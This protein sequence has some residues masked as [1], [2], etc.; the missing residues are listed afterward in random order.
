MELI[1]IGVNRKVLVVEHEHVNTSPFIQ[2][3]LYQSY[4]S[5]HKEP[6]PH[7]PLMQLHE[8]SQHSR[9]I[10]RERLSQSVGALLWGDTF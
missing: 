2:R 4:T 10:C 9:N 6:L 8:D 1:N 5:M 3:Y 7:A